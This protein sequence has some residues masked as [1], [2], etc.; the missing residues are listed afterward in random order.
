MEV[1]DLSIASADPRHD[2]SSSH[3]QRT[4][5]RRAWASVGCHQCEVLTS[6]RKSLR[7]L[8]PYFFQLNQNQCPQSESVNVLPFSHAFFQVRQKE[9]AVEGINGRDVGKDFHH[10]IHGECVFSCLF[11]QLGIKHLHS[12]ARV[13]WGMI[14]VLTTIFK[15][16]RLTLSNKL[17]RAT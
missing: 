16:F 2:Q 13:R 15:M 6:W 12:R 3:T 9:L 4:S 14:C 11:Y 5:S 1:I 7:A 8:R 17:S 10:H